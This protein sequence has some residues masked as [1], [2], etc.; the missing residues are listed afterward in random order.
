MTES[1]DSGM[2]HWD[3]SLWGV[4]RKDDERSD[5]EKYPP[6]APTP[7]GTMTPVDEGATTVSFSSA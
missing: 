5:E 6:P 4:E 2:E 1:G 7:P 3:T